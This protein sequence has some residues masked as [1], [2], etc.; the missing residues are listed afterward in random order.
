M[1]VQLEDWIERSGVLSTDDVR[2]IPKNN[3]FNGNK[4][5]INK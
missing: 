3:I 1:L 4:E 2:S 5:N